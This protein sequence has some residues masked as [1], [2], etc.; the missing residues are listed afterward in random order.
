MAQERKPSANAPCNPARSADSSNDSTISPRALTRSAASITRSYN[1]SGR[2][3]CRSNSRGLAWVAI[4]SASR[5]PRV[6]TS[7]VRSPLR[8]SSAL[9]ATVVP[10]F[11]QATRCAGIDSSGASPSSRRMPSTAASGY[12]DGFSDKSLWVCSAPSGA[13]PTMS[14][15]VPPRSIQ[16]CHRVLMPRDSRPHP[17]A[18]RPRSRATRWHTRLKIPRRGRMPC[19]TNARPIDSRRSGCR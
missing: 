11:T 12:C 15:K 7:T 14:V 5:K 16:N 2:T 1:I 8:S 9:V 19:A 4:R 18:A 13:H 3:M 10:I 17:L 6:M